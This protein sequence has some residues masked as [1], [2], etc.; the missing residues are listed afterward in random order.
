MNKITLIYDPVNGVALRDGELDLVAS[1]LVETGGE[2]IFANEVFLD[3]IRVLVKRGI[4][5]PKNIE[6][7]WTNPKGVLI[8]F[9]FNK[10]GI[11]DY[12]PKGFCDKRDG[13]LN[14]LINWG[15]E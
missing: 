8:G 5:K 2:F 11:L 9:N 3:S 6:V 10:F 14:E 13:Y 1:K 4:I 12:W 15:K 7:R